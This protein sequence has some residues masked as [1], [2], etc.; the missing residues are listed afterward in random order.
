MCDA[1]SF[2]VITTLLDG[3]PCVTFDRDFRALGL[4]VMD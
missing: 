2:I 3:M 4:T 1:I